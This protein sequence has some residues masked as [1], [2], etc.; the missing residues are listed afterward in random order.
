VEQRLAAHELRA[1]VEPLHPAPYPPRLF[2]THPRFER[3]DAAGQI[4]PLP[5]GAH[6]VSDGAKKTQHS[7]DVRGISG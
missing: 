1:F 6:P 7:A 2:A 5:Q 3:G 4:A